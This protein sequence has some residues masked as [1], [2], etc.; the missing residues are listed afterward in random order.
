MLLP[1]DLQASITLLGLDPDFV[2]HMAQR[3]IA[4]DLDGGVDVTT[5][6]LVPSGV[7]VIA[8]FRMRVE[9][10]VAGIVIAKTILLEAC[11]GEVHFV[12]YMH[13]GAQAKAGE[14]IF[15]AIG[16]AQGLLTGE[17]SALNFLGRLSGIATATRAWSNALAGSQTQ[18]RD[19]RKTTPGLRAFEKF[20]VRM[21]GG[22]NHRMSL[23]DAAMI[24]DNH[25]VAAGS[26]T[27]AYLALRLRFPEVPVE[28][29]VDALSQLE[30]AVATGAELILLDNMSP[31]MC[32]LAVRQIAG[33][34][35]TEASGG[36]TLEN[37]RKYAEVGVDYIAV[38]ALTHSVMNI[39][40]GV[41]FRSEDAA[42]N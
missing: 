4:E 25:I 29:E 1:E 22:V 13:D 21:G 24:K 15:T 39:D 35:K 30:E 10:V 37:A 12:D 23:S 11:A 28:I 16:P 42:R 32:D 27:A 5:T 7:R 40:I 2:V 31:E 38:G 6:A 41:D 17:R 18:V 36:I 26:I 3:A 8:D 14:V 33:R 9:G 20:A 19:T 34:A